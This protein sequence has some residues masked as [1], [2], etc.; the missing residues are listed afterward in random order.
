MRRGLL[1]ILVIALWT[2]PATARDVVDASPPK[3]LAVTI[4]RD[5]NRGV[6]ETMD[7]NDP[8][9]FAMISETRTVTLPPGESTLRFEAF[10]RLQ[11]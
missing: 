1:L 10:A 9:G 11:H 4:Y 3:N 7:R 2:E 8:R 6:G 5:P